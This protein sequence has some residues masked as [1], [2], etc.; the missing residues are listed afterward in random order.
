VSDEEAATEKPSTEEPRHNYGDTETE[1]SA[2]Y[3][4]D[5]LRFL[6]GVLIEL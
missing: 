2:L 6:G 1:L 5:L 4:Q 3:V